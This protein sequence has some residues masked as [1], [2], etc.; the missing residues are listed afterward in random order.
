MKIAVLGATGL[1]GHHTA[2]AVQAA[3]H[4]LT[5]LHRVQSDVSVLS[6]T[7]QQ[8]VAVDTQSVP[9]MASALAGHD[10]VIHCAGY[11]P[12]IPRRWQTDVALATNQLQRFYDACAAS[13]I[14]KVVYLGAAIAL[15]TAPGGALGHEAC[16]YNAQPTSKNPYLQAKWAMHTMTLVKAQRGL[17]V[18]IGIPSM[19]LGE[20]DYGPTTG[21]WI[22]RLAN[23]QLS[24]YVNGQRNVIYAGDAGRGLV[25]V[26]EAG[27]VGEAYLLTGTN[28][29]LHDFVTQLATIA[30]R[31]MPTR[32]PL[33]VVKLI[34]RLQVLRYHLTQTE[35]NISETAI[36]VMSAGQFL[37]GDK[38][39]RELGFQAEVPLAHALQLSYDWFVQAG[40][41]DP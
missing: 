24:A 40:M 34:N 21:Q 13:Q 8:W 38:A 19:T 7:P 6:I 9:S 12:T 32:M 17:P 30:D 14:S 2:R 15:R 16:E 35:P 22:T 1:L 27:R 41:I 33:P 29:T 10:A 37:S 11:Y 25:R 4:E 5:V 39:A 28:I 3:G 18:S 23:G 26:A 31:P 36:A 20:Y